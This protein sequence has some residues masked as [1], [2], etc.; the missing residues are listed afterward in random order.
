MTPVFE[1]P[2]F[3]GAVAAALVLAIVLLAA[4]PADRRSVR[5]ALLL[6]VAA[7][8]AA[9]VAH[10]IE[11]A[12]A[13]R[14]IAQAATLAAGLV[15]ARLGAMF[16]FRV[17]LPAVRLAPARIAEDLFTAAAYVAWVFAWTRLI[18]MDATSVVATSAVVTA[19]V[20]FAMQ[21]TLGNV[22]GG[23]LLQMDSS[24]REGDWARVDDLTGRVAEVRWRYTTFETANGERVVVPNAWLLKN[25]FVVLGPSGRAAVR[26]WVRLPVDLASSPGDVAGVLGDCI[27]TADIPHLSRA[28]KPDVVL[29]E[30]AGRSA[31]YA[32]RYWLEDPA[33]ADAVD[34]AVR[35][36]A[37]AALARHGMKIGAAYQEQYEIRDDEAQRQAVQAAERERRV[38]ALAAVRLF[39]PL[40]DEERR[41]LAPHLRYAPFVAGDVIT[42]EGA[43]AHWLYLIISGRAEVSVATSTGPLPVGRLEAGDLFGEMGMLT[44]APRSATVTARTDVVCYRLDKEGF[45][46]VIHARPD[47]AEAMAQ[48]LAGRQA[49]T[50]E[51]RSAA[52]APVVAGHGEILQRVRRFFGL[53]ES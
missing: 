1:Q 31:T 24:L 35:V 5:N 36:H 7:A 10:R 33:H 13:G 52:A 21:D 45:E 50:R 18:G 41:A 4:R 23:V 29:L 16:A 3:G 14:W 38:Q 19:V 15:I 20:A 46:T 40:T 27:S 44:G 49:D 53:A 42:H 12:M 9:A 39:A 6:L 43:V 2:W 28:R 32:V 22:L 17:A 30:L 37:L 48:V 11:P 8:G 26:R 47:V 51:D 34:S 25:R